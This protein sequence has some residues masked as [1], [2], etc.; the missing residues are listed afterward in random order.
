[1]RGPRSLEGRLGLW[2]GLALSLVWTA[3]ASLT[4][5]LARHEIEMV[6]DS[7]LQET[8]QRILPLAV[9]DII[10]REEQGVTQRLA[11]IRDHDEFFTYVVRDREGRVLLQSRSADPAQF[12]VWDGTGF[13]QSAT[14]RF[15]SEE[16]VQGSIRITV[17]EPLK[18]RASAARDIQMGLGLPLLIVIPVALLAIAFAVRASLAPLRRFRE[19]LAVRGAR[20]LS[21][22]SAGDMPAEIVPVAATLNN[23]LER[24]SSAFEAERSF[25]A[26]AAHELRTP[27][28]G[29][30]VQA[31]R[32]QIETQD[33]GAKARAR[34]IEAT[35]KRL[36]GLSE[37]LMQLARAE[38]GQ[39]RLN[40]A[41]DMRPV[42]QI[43]NDDLLRNVAQ[44]RISM[45]LASEP[46]MSDF[47]PDAFAIVY[48]NLIENALRHG[49][50]NGSISVSLCN[51]GVLTVTND[52]PLVPP[53]VL[54]RLTN[55]F[56]RS[57]GGGGAGLG[58]A[59]VASIAERGDCVLCLHSPRPGHDSGFEVSLTIPVVTPVVDTKA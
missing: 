3:A 21:P 52:G 20:D 57:G 32:L 48:R 15:Y 54:A 10:S 27:L 17:A 44:E 13:K 23:L 45:T 6:F 24:L 55:R 37:R 50:K 43:L 56:E 5:L 22:V 2:L 11:A 29:A 7:A 4:T 1:M 39:L 30:I 41:T 28:A 42:V 49:S 35:L 31:Q 47:D 16:A 26:N 34:D 33:A 38:G 18:H 40:R 8:A 25:A 46:V 53:D 9:V 59:I 36:A 12:P 19:R 51:Q 14:H 58:L